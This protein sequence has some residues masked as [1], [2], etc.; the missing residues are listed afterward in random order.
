VEADGSRQKPF[1]ASGPYEPVIPDCTTH[2]ILVAGL[3]V[4]GKI[5]DDN[6]VHR[7]QIFSNNTGLA[8]G[9]IINEQS[10]A[11]SIDIE[12]KKAKT[13]CCPSSIF[14]ILNKAETIKRANSGKRIATLLKK[15]QNIEKIITISLKNQTYGNT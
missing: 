10:I 11:E 4:V 15:N 2:L 1:K 8:M 6:F 13:F 7:A 14:V 9:K 12:I 3:D 5:L